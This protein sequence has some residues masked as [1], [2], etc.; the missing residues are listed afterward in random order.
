MSDLRLS[1]DFLPGLLDY[2][3]P[4][5]D[6]VFRTLF[7]YALVFIQVPTNYL[8]IETHPGRFPTWVLKVR[9]K[10]GLFYSLVFALVSG[11]LLLFYIVYTSLWPYFDPT[12][13]RCLISFAPRLWGELF[14]RL[15]GFLSSSIWP[16]IHFPHVSYLREN[17]FRRKK[18]DF[19]Y[20]QKE[21]WLINIT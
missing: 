2:Q 14:F 11:V 5:L 12:Q 17:I 13:F 8:K 6:S 16:P 7:P 9:I 10:K 1:L 3:Q 15:I 20:K 4:C 21:R 19:L 18:C